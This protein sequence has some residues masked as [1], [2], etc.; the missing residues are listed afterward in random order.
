VPLSP[1]S[2][3]RVVVVVTARG[4]PQRFELDQ[5]VNGG[6]FAPLG[7]VELLAGRSFLIEVLTE[8]TGGVDDREPIGIDAF[9]LS[10]RGEGTVNVGGTCSTSTACSG[11]AVCV[12]GVCVV[13]CDG[14]SCAVN[15]VCSASSGLCSTS[16]GEGEGEGAEGEGE[17]AEGE[18]EGEGAEGEGEGA[19][20]EGEGEPRVFANSVVPGCGCGSTGDVTFGAFAL[21]LFATRRRR[22]GGHASQRAAA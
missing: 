4:G 22:T 10:W 13:G 14:D 8:G 18:G 15:E 20:G 1:A 6:F 11:D 3:P 12:G 5:S 16:A 7:E 19:E 21:V 9:S 2:N 17:G